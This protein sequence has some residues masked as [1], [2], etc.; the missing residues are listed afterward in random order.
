MHV[1]V[2]DA[3]VPTAVQLVV[4]GREKGARAYRRDRWQLRSARLPGETTPVVCPHEREVPQVG[5]GPTDTNAEVIG[6][7]RDQ[8]CTPAY[9]ADGQVRH[10]AWVAEITDLLDVPDWPKECG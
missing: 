2:A 7:I 1:V 8:A 3:L 9:D 10:G 6:L 4:S 5:F